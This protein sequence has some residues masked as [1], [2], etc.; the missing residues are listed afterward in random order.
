[1]IGWIKKN[2]TVVAGAEVK[3]IS[4]AQNFEKAAY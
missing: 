3:V 2:I 4:S 1:M